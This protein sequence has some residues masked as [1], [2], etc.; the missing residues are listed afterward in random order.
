MNNHTTPALIRLWWNLAFLP[1]AVTIELWR[2]VLPA[3]PADD[4]DSGAPEGAD[5]VR[6]DQYR[7]AR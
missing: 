1:V 5:V 3:R 7:E 2:D 4:A 6:L